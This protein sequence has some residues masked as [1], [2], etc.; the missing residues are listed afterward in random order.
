M[1]KTGLDLEAAERRLA[2]AGGRIAKAIATE[3]SHG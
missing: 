1:G 2:E 3:E